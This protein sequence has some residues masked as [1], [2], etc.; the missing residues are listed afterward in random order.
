M[1]RRVFFLAGVASLLTCLT[2][3]VSVAG[4]QAAWNEGQGHPLK[5]VWIGDWGTS[6]TSRTDVLIEMNW[7]GKAVTATLNPG[8]TGMAFAKAEL[9]HTNWTVH[10]DTTSVGVR[11]LIDGKIENLGSNSRSIVGTWMQGNQKGDFK[12][13]RQ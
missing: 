11:Y 7:D 12:I 2:I 3:D 13:T 6:K 4:A 10:L 5:G 8:A 1:T 9:D